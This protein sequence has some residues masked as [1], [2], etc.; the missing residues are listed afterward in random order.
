MVLTPRCSDIN[1]INNAISDNCGIFVQR[2]TTFISGFL[3]GFLNGWKLT[4]II[5]AVSPALGIGAG[6]MGMV[7]DEA[8][9]HKGHIKEWMIKL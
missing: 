3:I 6:L 7:S 8:L 5:L 4:L 2:F 1:K 9:L